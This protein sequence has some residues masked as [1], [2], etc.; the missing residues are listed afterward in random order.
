MKEIMNYPALFRALYRERGIFL[1]A[2]VFTT[3]MTLIGA[4][5][6]QDTQK[7]LMDIL[8][9]KLKG[10]EFSAP[11]IFLNNL[12][13]GG[14]ILLGGI[15]FSLPSVI[16]VGLNFLVLGTAMVTLIPAHGTAF[17]MASLLPHGI[18]EIPAILLSFV[19][20]MMIT[21]A[22]VV[23]I[24]GREEAVSSRMLLLETLTLAVLM[25]LPLLVIAALIEVYVTPWL[26]GLVVK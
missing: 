12:R 3:L 20:A 5:L 1:T 4:L 14:I 2:V 25:I 10:V 26:T 24:T 19:G 6:P 8:Y 23:R 21:K 15:M 9:D 16:L 11:G 7:T 22:V 13:S 17:M 18:F